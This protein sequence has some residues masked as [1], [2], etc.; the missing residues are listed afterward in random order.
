MH[1]ADNLSIWAAPG[2]AAAY[3]TYEA[4]EQAADVAMKSNPRIRMF[5]WWGNGVVGNNTGGTCWFHNHVTVSGGGPYSLEVNH[6]MG[7]KGP[8]DDAPPRED[9]PYDMCDGDCNCGDGL[10]CGEYLWDHRNGSML[11]DFLV[12]DFVL[13]AKT[14]LQ[15]PNIDGFYFDDYWTNTPSKVPPWAPPTY[16]PRTWSNLRRSGLLL[17]TRFEA[18]HHSKQQKLKCRTKNTKK[19]G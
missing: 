11:Q 9:Y 16:Q 12:N 1:P 18:S 8:A 5:T 3:P 19:K 14:G 7:Y 6:V 2:A 17:T 4:C 13:N 15:N 10:P